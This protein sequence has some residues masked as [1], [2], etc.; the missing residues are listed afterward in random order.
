MLPDQKIILTS[1]CS[2]YCSGELSLNWTLYEYDHVNQPEPTDLTDLN[3]VPQKEFENMA[4]NP[5]N[6]LEIAIK[7]HSLKAGRKYTIAFRATRP[8]GIFGEYRTTVFVN[9]PPVGG[10]FFKFS[11]T[12]QF[13]AC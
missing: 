10:T 5:T 1:S 3:E 7:P 9:S 8:N 11:S 4:A 6:E 2:K 12:F 13:I